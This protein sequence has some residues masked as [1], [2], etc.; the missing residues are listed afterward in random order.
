MFIAPDLTLKWRKT[1]LVSLTQDKIQNL[2]DKF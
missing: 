2:E 1:L